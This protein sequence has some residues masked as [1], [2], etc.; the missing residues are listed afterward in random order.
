MKIVGGPHHP[1]LIFTHVVTKNQ[2]GTLRVEYNGVRN[3]RQEIKKKEGK[4]C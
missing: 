3:S 2:S 4:P 1:P